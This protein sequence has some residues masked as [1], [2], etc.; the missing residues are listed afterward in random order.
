MTNE[1]SCRP[2]LLSDKDNVG[3]NIYSSHF[4]I[5]LIFMILK[6]WLEENSFTFCY[7]FFENLKI[8]FLMEINIICFIF[9][10]FSSTLYSAH[11]RVSRE[12]VG[13]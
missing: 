5:F 12:N 11:S 7:I 8:C 13:T 9:L 4:C 6:L 2:P 1:V 3:P 10:F